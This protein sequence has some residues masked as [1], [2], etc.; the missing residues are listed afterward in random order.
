MIL[1]GSAFSPLCR[2]RAP[3]PRLP[4]QSGRWPEVLTARCCWPT[5]LAYARAGHVLFG[6]DWPFAPT[7]AGLHFANGL[8]SYPGL[9][10]EDLAAIN[11]GAAAALFPRLGR[12]PLA[13][14]H[15]PLPRRV[16]AGVQRAV[17]RPVFK[18]V[19]PN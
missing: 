7:L 4:R 17:T 1:A 19:Q 3:V 12:T 10:Q 2:C 11:S 13:A 14:Q 16:C 9:S 6:S 18:L 8:D 5:L 15:R